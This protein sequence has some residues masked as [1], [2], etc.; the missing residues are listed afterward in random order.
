MR[1]GVT[2]REKRSPVVVPFPGIRTSLICEGDTD[3]ELRLN[4]IKWMLCMWRWLQVLIKTAETVTQ[5][6]AVLPSK[7]SFQHCEPPLSPTQALTHP[8]QGQTSVCV[9]VLACTRV[10]V[11]PHYPDLSSVRP[12]SRQGCFGSHWK[13][14]VSISLWAWT[15]LLNTA[16]WNQFVSIMYINLSTHTGH[17]YKADSI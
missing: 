4:L 1:N 8:S 11:H 5:Q 9:C 3:E 6:F 15:S 17:K 13:G 7:L 10:C 2:V 16:G 12:P 14:W